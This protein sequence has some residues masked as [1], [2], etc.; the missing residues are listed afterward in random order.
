MKV[1]GNEF[2]NP[3]TQ[4]IQGMTG[5]EYEDALGVQ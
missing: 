4:A 5:D 2:H 3:I 1:D